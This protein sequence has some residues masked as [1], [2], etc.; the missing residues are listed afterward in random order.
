[1]SCLPVFY[2]PFSVYLWIL[3]LF[4]VPLSKLIDYNNEVMKEIPL[5]GRAGEREVSAGKAPSGQIPDGQPGLPEH[6]AEKMR[7]GSLGGTG[8]FLREDRGVEAHRPPLPGG[9]TE[10]PCLNDF[11]DNLWEMPP[12]SARDVSAALFFQRS[13]GRKQCLSRQAVQQNLLTLIW[14]EAP[15]YPLGDQRLSEMLSAAG[16]PVA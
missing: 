9:K 7:R 16:V 3:H 6:D 14:E 2:Y 13:G 12:M 1:M 4:I 11:P 10:F 5:S 15:K 8:L